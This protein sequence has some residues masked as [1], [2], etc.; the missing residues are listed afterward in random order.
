MKLLLGAD[1]SGDDLQ[2]AEAERRRGDDQQR[3]EAV[4]QRRPRAPP[5][6]SQE[7]QRQGQRANQHAEEA[8]ESDG[9]HEGTPFRAQQQRPGSGTGLVDDPRR[10]QHNLYVAAAHQHPAGISPR[11]AHHGQRHALRQRRCQ[12]SLPL[13]SPSPPQNHAESSGPREVAGVLRF[14]ARLHHDRPRA[15]VRLVLLYPAT[16]SEPDR[17]S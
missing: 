16:W 11:R 3:G 13:V 9:Q 4:E 10:S 7:V 17:D 12:V 6:P 14:L 15:Q 1:P 5:P 2:E 8:A